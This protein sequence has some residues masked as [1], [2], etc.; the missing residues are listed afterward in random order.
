MLSLLAVQRAF[1]HAVQLLRSGLAAQHV[2]KADLGGPEEAD[3]EVTVSCDA[4]AAASAA[5]VLR[6]ARDE[7]DLPR[8]FGHTISLEGER[9]PFSA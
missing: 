1:D 2:A 6:H 8:E 5:E 9:T 3:L 7:T 4:H